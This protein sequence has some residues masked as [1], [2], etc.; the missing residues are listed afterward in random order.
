MYLSINTGWISESDEQETTD[1]KYDE[2]YLC[3]N[4]FIR[5]G[6]IDTQQEWFDVD[7]VKNWN[8]FSQECV[9]AEHITMSAG[10]GGCY[11]E[12]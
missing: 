1:D 6:G 7:D 10:S 2:W 4:K 8:R 9:S 12:C 11:G 5:V 3:V